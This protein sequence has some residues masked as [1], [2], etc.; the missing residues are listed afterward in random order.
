MQM[1]KL[2]FLKNSRLA[3]G[4]ALLI[5]AL[6]AA[7]LIS[8][9]A[10]RTVLVWASVGE[11]APGQIITPT[12]IIPASVLLA[13]SAKNYFSSAAQIV[14]ATVISRISTGDLI[15]V[16]AISNEVDSTDKRLVPLSVEITDLP[17][18]LVRGD[19]IDIYAIPKRDSKSIITPEL[20]AAGVSVEQVLERSNSGSVSVLV[21]LNSDQVISALNLITDS[22]LIIVRSF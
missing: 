2:D 11:L 7:S 5:I 1:A 4:L 9:E 21:I 22:R 13:Q 16:A 6:S 18:A 17:I 20:L 8:K 14:G 15:P 19:V 3:M 12:D 10:N